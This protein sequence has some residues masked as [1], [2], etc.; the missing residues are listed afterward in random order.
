MERPSKRS[1]LSRQGPARRRPARCLQP[2]RRHRLARRGAFGPELPPSAPRPAGAADRENRAAW[3]TTVDSLPVRPSRSSWR[4]ATPTASGRTRRAPRLVVV[5]RRAVLVH[6]AA[7]PQPGDLE[8]YCTRPCTASPSDRSGS[9]R[10]SPPRG[11]VAPACHPPHHGP[12]K[13]RASAPPAMAPAGSGRDPVTGHFDDLRARECRPEVARRVPEASSPRQ[14]VELEPC[15]PRRRRP[16]DAKPGPTLPPGLF[17]RRLRVRREH[18]GTRRDVRGDLTAAGIHEVAQGTFWGSE[19]SPM[20][21]GDGQW[22]PTLTAAATIAGV[23]SSASAIHG[24]E[25]PPGIVTLPS[26]AY[27]LWSDGDR[28]TGTRSGAFVAAF[29]ATPRAAVSPSSAPSWPKLAVAPRRGPSHLVGA[30][31]P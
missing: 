10:T 17:D 25:P 24:G 8:F 19:R 28:V 21:S 7:G 27:L 11:T 9:D 18:P 31:A 22:R 15:P 14:V 16:S 23:S 4:R 12:E 13:P 26:T 2:R 29:L 6:A 30:Y 20:P 3:P 5:A 1:S